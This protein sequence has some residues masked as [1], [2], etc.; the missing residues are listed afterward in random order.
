QLYDVEAGTFL[1]DRFVR[2][3]CPNPNC[4]AV[5]QPG[6]NCSVCGSTYSP[7]DLIEPRSTLTGSKPEVRSAPHLFIEL[8][9]LHDF[10]D[11]WTQS[12]EHLQPETANYLKG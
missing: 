7:T 2:G 11:E 9:Q 1:A 12:G 8:E 4:R 3:T 5:N 10:L 6:D